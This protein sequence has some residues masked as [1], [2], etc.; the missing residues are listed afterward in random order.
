MAKDGSMFSS[1]ENVIENKIFATYDFALNITGYDDIACRRGQIVDV[2]HVPI[3]SD[4]LF[5][6]YQLTQ[7]GNIFEF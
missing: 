7:N 2:F 1:F 5:S 6:V 3:L 4:N